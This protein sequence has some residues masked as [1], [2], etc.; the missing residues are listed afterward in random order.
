[1]DIDLIFFNDIVV[2]TPDLTLPHPRMQLRRFVLEPLCEIMP[3]YR[4]PLLGK[5]VKEL[6]EA[7]ETEE[8]TTE[9]KTTEKK[10]TEDKN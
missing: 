10:T 7:L 1:M 3:D 9:K 6:L 4:H 2:D 8:K 5:S